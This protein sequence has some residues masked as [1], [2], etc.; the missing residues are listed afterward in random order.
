MTYVRTPDGTRIHYSVTGR[1]GAPPILFIQGLGADK[2]GWDLQRLATA[3]WYQAVALDNRGAGR[4]D[5]PRGEYTLEQMADDAVA[6]LD[7]AGVDTAHVVGASMGGAISQ[8]IAVKYPERTRSLTLACTAG[9][10]HPWREELL[11]SWRDIALERGISSMSQ[12]A[13]RWVIGPRSFR[14]LMPAMGW[15]GPLALGR[16]AHAFAA[17]CDAI[18]ERGREARGAR[19]AAAGDRRADARRRREPGHPHA[20]R[21]QRGSRRSHPDRR[22]GRDQRCRARF[23]GRAR[24]HVQPGAARVP[25]PGGE[26]VPAADRR[27]SRRRCTCR[28]SPPPAVDARRRHRCRDGG[29]RGG[30]DAARRVRRRA[31]HRRG[32]QG[33]VGRRADGDPPDRGRHVRSRRAVL[34]RAHAGVPAAG[35]RLDGSRAG[36]CL[37]PRFRPRRRPSPLRRS[38]RHDVAGEGPGRRTAGR[39]FDDGVHAAPVDR[40][41]DP[42]GGGDRRRHHAAGGLRDHHDAAGAGVRTARRRRP[43]TGRGDVPR[44]LRP[45]DLPA[46]RARPARRRVVQRRDATGRRGVQLHRRQHVEGRQRRAGDHVPCR[47][48]VERSALGRPGRRP[49]PG[50]DRCGAPVARRRRRRRAPREEVAIRHA[51]DDLARPV[52]DARRTDRSCSPAIRSPAHG[53]KVPTTPASPPPTPS[54]ADGP[55]LRAGSARFDAN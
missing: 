19:R 2:H 5:K 24:Q 53:S 4:S 30:A 16:P 35:R 28:S 37:E 14:R 23:H 29:P 10:N 17:Q 43:R 3:P 26:G 13:A 38:G 8:I 9:R 32:R 52:P 45:D 21:R 6:V 42:L 44:R 34:H 25:R 36:A 31:R 18:L 20:A 39:V 7:D 41:P 51:A 54:C 12:E 1:P 55:E 27:P 15:L 40:G 11:A 49:R 47:S 33:S 50:A 48:D 46:R 22:A